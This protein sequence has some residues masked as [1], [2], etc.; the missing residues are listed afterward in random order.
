MIDTQSARERIMSEVPNVDSSITGAFH[1][2]LLRHNDYVKGYVTMKEK[3][4]EEDRAARRARR[5][6]RELKLLFS[7]DEKVCTSDVNF[8]TK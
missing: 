5:Q 7:M 1:K 8:F 2:Y 6:P 4:E 3:Q